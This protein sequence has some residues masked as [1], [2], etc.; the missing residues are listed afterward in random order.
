MLRMG[1]AIAWALCTGGCDYLFQIDKVSLAH[2]AQDARDDGLAD[3]PP[4][5]MCTATAVDDSFTDTTP[6]TWGTTF[7]GTYVTSGGGRLVISPPSDAYSGGCD[8]PIGAFAD[9]GI[10]AE[11][12]KVIGGSA[13]AFTGIQAFGTFDVSIQVNAGEL[14]FEDP[15]ASNVWAHVTYD[16]IA[17]RWVRLRPDHARNAIAGEYSSDGKT[18]TLLAYVSPPTI[19]ATVKPTLI[20]GVAQGASSFTGVAEFS[21]FIVCL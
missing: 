18:W 7:G 14:K 5:G 19:P 9:G 2:D 4:P 20:G 16:P 11:I 3:G 1:V 15:D 21:R 12:T 13:Y 10:V 17:M 6:C 8:A